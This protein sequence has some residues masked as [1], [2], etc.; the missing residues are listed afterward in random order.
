VKDGDISSGKF[1]R[2]IKLNRL[3]LIS[4]IDIDFDHKGGIDFIL[5][6]SNE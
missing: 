2:K 1:I 5:N 4:K 3:K 6:L